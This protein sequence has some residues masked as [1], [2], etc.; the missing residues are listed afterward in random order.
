[1]QDNLILIKQLQAKEERALSK[2]YDLY[3]GAVFGVIK[4]M[5]HDDDL[6]KDLLQETFIKVWEKSYLYDPNKGKFFTWLYRIARN[7]VLNSLRTKKQLIQNQDLS[8]YNNKEGEENSFVDLDE[9]KGALSKLENHHQKA[10]QLV[11]FFGLTHREAHEEMGVP[12]GTFKSYVRQALT[13]LKDIYA[14]ETL[15]VLMYI[16]LL[17]A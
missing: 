6:A 16:V 4:K 15:V 11:Y 17:L 8:V 1:M 13:K 14:E 10:L 2:I 3:S 5:C 7:T 12:L 9:I